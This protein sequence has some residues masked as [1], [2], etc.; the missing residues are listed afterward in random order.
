VGT[1]RPVAGDQTPAPH[2]CDAVRD[3]PTDRW[4]PVGGVGRAQAVTAN[5]GTRRS[6]T[7]LRA[8]PLGRPARYADGVGKSLL[9]SVRGRA[10]VGIF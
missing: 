7:S 5:R 6:A 1:A 4:T 3:S 8:A 2:R 9:R 10:M